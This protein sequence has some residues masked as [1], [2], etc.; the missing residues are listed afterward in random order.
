MAAITRLM[1]YGEIFDGTIKN[2]IGQGSGG[3]TIVYRLVSKDGFETALK[4]VPIFNMRGKKSYYADYQVSRDALCDKAGLEVKILHDLEEVPYVMQYK[5]YC[6]KDW[7]EEFSFGCDMLI[8]MPLLENIYKLVVDEEPL[9]EN[10][11]ITLGKNL[12]TALIRCHQMNIIHR[13]IKPHNIFRNKVGDYVL[14]DFG[15]ARIK[16][17]EDDVTR[18]ECT[19]PF[20]APEQVKFRQA[21][22]LTD[23]YSLGLSLYYLSNN[24]RLP[25]LSS[26]FTL[27]P[28]DANQRR[29]DG[30]SLPPPEFCSKALSGIILKACAYRPENR[31]QS[32]E[33]F[34]YCLETL[35]PPPNDRTPQRSSFNPAI[36]PQKSR[37]SDPYTTDVASPGS[38]GSIMPHSVSDLVQYETEYARPGDGFN[39]RNGSE[40]AGDMYQTD[41]AHSGDSFLLLSQR[42]ISGKQSEI[43]QHTPTA[44]LEYSVLDTAQLAQLAAEGD[45]VAQYQFGEVYRFGGK[46]ISPNPTKAVVWLMRAAEQGDVSA[47]LSLSECYYNGTGVEEDHFEAVKWVRRAAEQGDSTAYWTL[48]VCYYRD[49]GVPES[50]NNKGE[51]VKWFKMAAERG[52]AKAQSWLADCYYNGVGVLKDV[53]QAVVW[54]ERATDLG[55]PDGQFGLA[56]C[57]LSGDGIR[58]SPFEAIKLLRDAASQNHVGAQYYLG[59]CYYA[60]FNGITIDHTEAFIWFRKAAEHG[61]PDAQYRLGDCF[62]Y[63]IGTEKSRNKAIIWYKAAA[64]GGFHEAEE[65][66]KD[67]H[68][69]M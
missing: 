40:S 7:D 68:V 8:Q 15:I 61:V 23:I 3:T 1:Q 12:C 53:R 4:V 51:A 42:D 57:Y 52:H 19:P 14:G 28:D 44:K 60:G 13:D 48:G 2:E 66:L 50:S 41:V 58:K 11:I 69:S 17:P 32:A 39:A 30:A 62:L 18:I 65:K 56:V 25:F 47:Q 64:K 24:N 54:Y 36:R 20:A 45:P 9:S 31:F 22:Q 67:L 49:D 16:R 34:L 29:I 46:G 38:M 37:V 35:S 63:G 27:N 21:N 5:R 59:E 6:F 55:D 10:Q 33:E 26:T 43:P